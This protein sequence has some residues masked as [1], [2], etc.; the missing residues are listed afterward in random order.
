[1]RLLIRPLFDVS[2]AYNTNLW[3]VIYMYNASKIVII[4]M[5]IIRTG[6]NNIQDLLISTRHQGAD[7]SVELQ[8]TGIRNGIM[9]NQDSFNSSP[10]KYHFLLM[11][12][13]SRVISNSLCMV[14][15]GFNRTSFRSSR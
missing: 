14:I 7:D 11:C 8:L 10:N 1:M 5:I 6:Q 15:I 4:N 2:P 9:S 12:C 13:L 3:L